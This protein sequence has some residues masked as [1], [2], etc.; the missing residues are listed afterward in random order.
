MP[1]RLIPPAKAPGGRFYYVHGSHLGVAVRRSAR[2]DRRALAQAELKR[3][4]REIE[5]GRYAAPAPV[6]EPTFA[7][8]A[9]GYLKTCAQSEVSRV[10]RLLDHFQ[11]TPLSA[12]NLALIEEAEEALYPGRTATTSPAT[13]NREYRSP[14]AAV[15]HHA[16]ERQ[17]MAWLK[18]KRYQEKQRTRWHE[19]EAALKLIAAAH[20]Y[21]AGKHHHKDRFLAP[22]LIGAY[23]TGLRIS[24]LTGI[25]WGKVNLARREVGPLVTK[26]GEEYV[27][28][29]GDLW[30]EAIA[31]LPKDGRHPERRVFGFQGRHAVKWGLAKACETAGM[32]KRDPDTGA[33][34]RDNN[35]RA[36]TT[37]TMH[38]AR[39]SFATWLRRQE[40][41][42]LKKLMELGRWKDIKSVARYAHV[43][44]EEHAPAIARLPINRKKEAS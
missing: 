6:G 19:P 16:A 15:L 10:Q 42:D 1:L 39:H 20:A 14:L 43:A 32:V 3:L 24:E 13:L 37:F 34:L 9:L 28:H 11:I 8:A 40:G 35:G 38:Q 7:D 22:L 36:K 29:M 18:V 2:T 26:N 33:T 25:T 27:V 30:F 41:M 17:L 44:A 31:N 4:E 21:D 12:F 5:H 23:T